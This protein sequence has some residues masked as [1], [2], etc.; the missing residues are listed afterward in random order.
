[1]EQFQIDLEIIEQLKTHAQVVLMAALLRKYGP[2]FRLT[3]EELMRA[4]VEEVV[5]YRTPDETIWRLAK[6]A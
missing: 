2:E 6:E 3:N 5:T 4:R 1:M